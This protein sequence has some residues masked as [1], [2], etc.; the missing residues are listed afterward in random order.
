VAWFRFPPNRRGFSA[1]NR[2]WEGW[3]RPFFK[4]FFF[5]PPDPLTPGICF[6]L[7]L[8]P[9]L[10][11]PRPARAAWLPPL[12]DVFNSPRLG[13][14]QKT[15]IEPRRGAGPQK[16]RGKDSLGRQGE[17]AT[18]GIPGGPRARWQKKGPGKGAPRPGAG[19]EGAIARPVGPFI[20][21]PKKSLPPPPKLSGGQGWEARAHQ[22]GPPKGRAHIFLLAG[23]GLCGPR[24]RHAGVYGF[25]GGWPGLSGGPI[26]WTPNGEFCT[27]PRK[28]HF[29]TRALQFFPRAT[30]W[31][32]PP[33]A[34][35]FSG[36]TPTT[37]FI[38]PAGFFRTKG[39]LC[40]HPQPRVGFYRPG[41]R[42]DECPYTKR[43]PKQ[44]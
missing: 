41:A 24:G 40:R 20:V 5:P 12:R 27:S 43:G 37:S 42:P 44:G 3:R 34:R 32:R 26:V 23:P 18:R 9:G 31:P 38:S 8:P 36:G 29:T 10:G 33:Q 2:S 21:C 6:L 16:G 28:T 17:G 7:F 39:H 19:P 35:F 14:P 30:G 1:V 13:A 22:M 4:D 25:P 11:G 15:R